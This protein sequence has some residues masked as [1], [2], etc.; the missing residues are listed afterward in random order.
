MSQTKFVLT[1]ALH[2]KLLPIVV[3]NKV[4][5]LRDS[6]SLSVVENE[7]FELFGSLEASNEQM[8]YPTLYASGRNGWAIKH[9]KEKPEDLTPL[10]ETIVNYSLKFE[11]NK[12]SII[13]KII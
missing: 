10:F 11:K 8:E 12:L 2:A 13:I 9:P 1:K 6:H 7:I 3:L 5:R 4:D